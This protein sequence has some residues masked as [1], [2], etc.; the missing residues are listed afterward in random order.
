VDG[1]P[2]PNVAKTFRFQDRD[3]RVAAR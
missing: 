1:K 3:G 2:Y